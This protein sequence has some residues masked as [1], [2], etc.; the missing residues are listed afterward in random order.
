MSE[1]FSAGLG[2]WNKSGMTINKVRVNKDGI[3]TEKT[4]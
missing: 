1:A 2:R 3:E 4:E